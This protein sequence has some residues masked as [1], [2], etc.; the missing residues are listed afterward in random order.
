MRARELDPEKGGGHSPELFALW[1][2][3]KEFVLRAIELNPFNA[4]RFVWCDAGICRYPA[5]IP[6]LAE[7]FALESQVPAGKML[8]LTIDPFKGEDSVPAADG[9][10]GDFGIRAS[11][12]GGILAS[13]AEGWK[14]WSAAYDAMLMRYYLAGRFIG[15]DQNIMGS[16]LLERPDLAVSV[17]RNP[18]LSPAQSWFSLLFY[19]A[20]V[21]PV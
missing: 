9:I 20:G 21:E 18:R 8:V 6:R 1:Y 10:K 7:R 19:L 11:V 13:D 14:T 17:P 15:K 5:W 4:S 2:E 3:K 12:G 16:M